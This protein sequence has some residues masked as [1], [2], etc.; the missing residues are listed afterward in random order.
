MKNIKKY[1]S[2]PFIG[3]VITIAVLL[4]KEPKEQND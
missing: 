3:L 1:L 2:F 4:Y